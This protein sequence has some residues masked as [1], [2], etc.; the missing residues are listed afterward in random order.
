MLYLLYGLSDSCLQYKNN[1]YKNIK[2]TFLFLSP[3]PT[4]FYFY[5]FPP[6]PYPFHP[7]LLPSV[8]AQYFSPDLSLPLSHFVASA[9]HVLDRL[10]LLSAHP[11]PSLLVPASKPR[12]HFPLFRTLSPQV[13]RNILYQAS[14]ILLV[15]PGF[16]DSLPSLLLVRVFVPLAHLRA[17]PFSFRSHSFHFLTGISFP[18]AVILSLFH[19]R[20]LF[21]F[22]IA[23]R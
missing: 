8:F 23:L 19:I 21:L 17:H 14:L 1:N 20:A 4:H 12:H 18:P 9:P 3:T 5:S 6:L 15:V 10:I 22:S 7:T 11:A 13:H 16:S 2:V